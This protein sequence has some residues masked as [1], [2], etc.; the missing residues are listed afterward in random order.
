MSAALIAVSVAHGAPV[1]HSGDR[2][3]AVAAVAEAAGVDPAT[4]QPVPFEALRRGPPVLTAGGP[5]VGCRGASGVDEALEKAEGVLLY[6][7]FEEAAARLDEAR[8]AVLC[9]T[10]DTPPATLARIEVFAGLL[11]EERRAPDLAA[12]RYRTALGFHRQAAWP[13]SYPPDRRTLFDATAAAFAPEATRLQVRPGHTVATIEGRPLPD[14]GEVAV[15]EHVVRVGA[16]A[17]RITL[18]PV[19]NQLVLPGAFP[20][21]ALGWADD[22]ERRGDLTALLAAGLGEGTAVWV[23]ADDHVWRGVAGRTDWDGFAPSAP[24]PRPEARRRGGLALPVAGV[25]T[26]LVGAGLGVGGTA[27][28]NGAARRAATSPEAWE[29]HQA[30]YRLGVGVLTVGWGLSGVG[31]AVGAVGV[32]R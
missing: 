25:V 31:A 14:G 7:R 32:V 3:A 22:D 21:E 6:G 28:A 5:A 19:P 29:A 16:V 11:A 8:D 23:V 12:A 9:A 15:G 2:A 10:A 27:L 13:D 1:V 26:T 24:E 18:D 30:R 20:D 4:L 17:A